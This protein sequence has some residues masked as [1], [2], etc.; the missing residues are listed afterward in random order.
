MGVL[1]CN[2]HEGSSENWPFVPFLPHLSAAAL[3]LFLQHHPS[4]H[5]LSPASSYNHPLSSHLLLL[6]KLFTWKNQVK[7]TDIFIKRK[8]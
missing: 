6:A 5:L 1:P 8:N 2:I 7:D 4:P 3:L